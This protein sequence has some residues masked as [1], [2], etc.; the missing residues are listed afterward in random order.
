MA[1]KRERRVI[2]RVT[3]VSV[4][5]ARR[6]KDRKARIRLLLD[7]LLLTVPYLFVFF[8]QLSQDTHSYPT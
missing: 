6:E 5:K 3:Q 1:R 8:I 2:A 4:D 7:R